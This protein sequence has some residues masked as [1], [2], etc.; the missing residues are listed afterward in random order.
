MN[1]HLATA[2]RIY[3]E[4]GRDFQA[5]FA[6]CLAVGEVQVHPEFFFMGWPDPAGFHIQMFA[7]NIRQAMRMHSGR[8]PNITFARAFEETSGNAPF[9]SNI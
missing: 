1:E 7:G 3:E 6:H 9:H 5:E 2:I 4:H 8:Y